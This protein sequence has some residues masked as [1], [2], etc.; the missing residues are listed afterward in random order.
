MAK[1]S[2]EK[3][4]EN[5][6][7]WEE[8]GVYTIRVLKDKNRIEL[9]FTSRLKNA[10]DIPDFS[11]HVR[12]AVSEVKDGFTILANAYEVEGF[13]GFSVTKPFAEIQKILKSKNPL[14]SASVTRKLG[15]K[16]I[17][18][19]IGKLSGLNSKVFDNLEDAKTW[20]DKR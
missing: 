6:R 10:D 17:V 13:P 4:N 8:A 5:V 9:I 11:E 1:E 2:G 12:K 18:G 7:V 14:R 15:H 3:K 16:M 20:L 19:T